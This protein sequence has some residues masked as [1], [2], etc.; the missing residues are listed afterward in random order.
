MILACNMLEYAPLFQEIA[1]GYFERGLFES[2][3]PL[4]E[5]LASEDEV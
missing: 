1:D 3:L 4:Y 5:D 2:A